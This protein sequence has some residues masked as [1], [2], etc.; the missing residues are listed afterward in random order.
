MYANVLFTVTD[1]G[2]PPLNDSETITITVNASPTTITLTGPA[3][4]EDN[5]LGNG[6]YSLLNYGGS[7]YNFAVGSFASYGVI[8]RA[9]IKWDLSSIPQGSTITSAEMSLYCHQNYAGG[10]ITIN[11]HRM[12]R[13]WIEG[14]LD[15]QDR[16]LENPAA[17]CWIEYG[18]GEAWDQAG[19]A[20]PG[21]RAAAVLASTTNSGTGWYTLNITAAVQNWV[22]GSWANDGLILISPN[23]NTDSLKYFAPSEYQDENLRVVLVITYL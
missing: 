7:T 15:S 11:A 9:L 18:N 23:E 20:G 21:D 1:D 14:T 13:D 22:D 6:S 16:L 5:V 3:Y 8:A 12:L 4:A 10:A 17:S 2:E 19:A